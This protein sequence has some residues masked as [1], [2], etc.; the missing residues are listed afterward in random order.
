MRNSNIDSIVFNS[1]SPALIQEEI[2]RI[3]K[4]LDERVGLTETE[5]KELRK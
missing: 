2:A 5:E 4:E 1:L 3:R